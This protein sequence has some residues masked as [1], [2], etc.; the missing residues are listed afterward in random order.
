MAVRHRD[1]FDDFDRMT[2]NMLANFGMPRMGGGLFDDPFA[3]D[4]F[5]KDSGFGRMNDIMK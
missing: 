5:F 2:S 4:P 3:N 1:P